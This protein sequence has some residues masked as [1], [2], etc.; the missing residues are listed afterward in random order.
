M[1]KL[2]EIKGYLLKFYAK[3]SKYVDKA[4]QFILALLTFAFISNNIGFSDVISNPVVTVALSIICT[5]LPMP[6]IVVVATI[7]TMFQLYTLSIGIAVVALILFLFV[8]AFYLRFTPGKAVILLLVPLA[9]M[10]QIPMV[11]P[12]IFGLIGTPV[13]IIPITMGTIIYYLIDCVNSYSTLLETAGESGMLGQMAT[14]TQQLLG[15]REMWCMIIGFAISLLLVYS[16][17]TMEVDHAWEIAIIAGILTHMITMTA[18]YV[19]FDV[20]ISFVSLI[21]GSAVGAIIAFVLELFVFTVDYSRTE[22]LQFEDDEYYYHVKAIPKV[23]VAVP[24]KTVKRINERQKTGF[25]DTEQ[26]LELERVTKVE[27]E[28][29]EIQKIIEE[30]LRS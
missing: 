29:S 9:C 1:G 24:E 5:F 16:L 11:I 18:G 26:V 20:Q 2:F 14:Y 30:E 10:L 25:I 3:Y 4:C 8:Y 23:S 27:V 17:R 12:I 6:V 15:N 19:V 22:Y 21:I 7:V 13:C 28:E